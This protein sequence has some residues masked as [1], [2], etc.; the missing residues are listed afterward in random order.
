MY[1][2]LLL[3]WFLT[4]YYELK[5]LSSQNMRKHS[6][7]FF[8]VYLYFCL[9]YSVSWDIPTH[10]TPYCDEIFN[11]SFNILS[12]LF[13]LLISYGTCTEQVSKCCSKAAV[14]INAPILHKEKSMLL[15][16]NITQNKTV[17][18]VSLAVCTQIVPVS[19]DHCRIRHLMVETIRS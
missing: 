16:S 14:L 15:E 9:A 3:R 17:Y 4:V 13:L 2:F 5:Y 7:M 1:I 19:L 10:D 6:A 12:L 18:T 11:T 8:I